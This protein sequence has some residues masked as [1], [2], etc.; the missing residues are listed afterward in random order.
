MTATDKISEAISII[1]KIFQLKFESDAT[2]FYRWRP[3][4]RQKSA[5]GIKN[6]AEVELT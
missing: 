5:I 3:N 1:D 4:L 2:L 6:A